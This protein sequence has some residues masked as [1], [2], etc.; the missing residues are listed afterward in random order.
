LSY[1]QRLSRVEA[2]REIDI[3]MIRAIIFDFNGVIADDE[4]PHVVCFQ[5][6]LAEV[7]LSLTKDEY[8]STYLGMDERTC[9]RMLL[10]ARDGTCE[11]GLLSRIAQRKAELFRA[12]T[13]AHKPALFP[14]VV[15]FVKAAKPSYRLAIASGGRREQIDAAL[16]GTP[17]EQDFELIVSAEDCPI[18][19]PAPAIYR[20]TCERLNAAG[21]ISHVIA[22]AHCLVIEDSL[23]GIRS[24][25]AAGMRVLAV[26]TTYPIDKLGEADGVV[27]SL[28]EVLP[29]VAIGRVAQT[30]Q[31]SWIPATQPQ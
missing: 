7:G 21:A 19:K 6:A 14:G 22:P 11:E 13:A 15:E 31:E 16:S 30:G 10:I 20:Y 9:A 3:T 27:T 1:D 25:K 23:A 17:I 24:A 12:F 4:T 2:Q 28:R 26:A 5:H 29:D 8:Y 18:G